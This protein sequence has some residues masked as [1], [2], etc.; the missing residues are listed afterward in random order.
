MF[1]LYFRRPR[2]IAFGPR[3]RNTLFWQTFAQLTEPAVKT[4]LLRLT[5][6]ILVGLS[7][8]VLHTFNVD[9]VGDSIQFKDGRTDV[10]AGSHPMV[11]IWDALAL[12]LFVALMARNAD[13]VVVGAP[14]RGRRIAAGLID[15]WF[16]LLTL[17]GI[18]ALV[19]LWL[20]AVRTG[21]FMWRFQRPYTVSTDGV[22][23]LPSMFAFLGLMVLYYVFPLTRGKQTV[24]CFIMRIKVTPPFGNRGK[25][26]F[27][28]AIR[29]AYYEF[30]GFS[31]FLW[32]SKNWDKDGHGRTWYDIKTNCT[33]VLVEDH[34][35]ESNS[36]LAR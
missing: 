12:A 8:V 1:L 14:S 31:P 25:F 18:S 6:A 16:S 30:N 33:V 19:P 20:E 3:G 22:F 17:S 36:P 15:F 13:V 27:R 10:S 5:S 9:Q 21:H 32:L 11:L 29:R 4:K 26:T 28:Q 2:T 34:V 7:F 23:A 24:G 35:A